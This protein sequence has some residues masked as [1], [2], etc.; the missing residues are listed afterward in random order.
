[1]KAVKTEEITNAVIEAIRRKI[2]NLRNTDTQNLST[3]EDV[4]KVSGNLVPPQLGMQQMLSLV[5]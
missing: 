4:G 2:Q 5:D 1:M 3:N